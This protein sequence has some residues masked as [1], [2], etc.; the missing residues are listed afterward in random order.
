[1]T[2]TGQR[3]NTTYAWQTNASRASGAP[4]SFMYRRLA[5]ERVTTPY[6]P[7]AFPT[8]MDESTPSQKLLQKLL[9]VADASVPIEEVLRL[10]EAACDAQDQRTWNWCVRLGSVL[11]VATTLGAVYVRCGKLSPVSAI[12]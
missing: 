12:A 2:K 5:E 3:K 6:S 9:T 10:C 4:T 7:Q 11:S 1:M 8:N